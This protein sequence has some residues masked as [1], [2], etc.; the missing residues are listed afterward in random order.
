LGRYFI[1]RGDEIVT[2][3]KNALLRQ[4]DIIVAFTL[5]LYEEEIKRWIEN[6]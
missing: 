6:L 4:G 2:L 5:S 1:Q 3:H